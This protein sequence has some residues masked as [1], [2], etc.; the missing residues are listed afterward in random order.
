MGTGSFSG[1]KRPGRGA[2]PPPPSKCRGLKNGRVIPL[3]TLKDLVAYKGG[4]FTFTF[5]P[6]IGAGGGAADK[7]VRYEP[8]GSGFDFR[9]RH[10][11]F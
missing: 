3:P 5:T 9:W 2:D 4:T 6:V 11:I 7:A 1:V 8:E 10:R